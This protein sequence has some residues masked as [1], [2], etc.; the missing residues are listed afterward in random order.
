MK[1][2]D[3][4]IIGQKAY[5]VKGHRKE[6][7]ELTITGFTVDADGYHLIYDNKDIYVGWQDRIFLSEKKANNFLNDIIKREEVRELRNIKNKEYIAKLEDSLTDYDHLVGS[8]VMLKENHGKWYK[9]KIK[10][11]HIVYR[12][13]KKKPVIGFYTLNGSGMYLLSREG[14]NW[15]FW[16]K[17][18]ELNTKLEKLQEQVKDVKKQIKDEEKILKEIQDEESN[19]I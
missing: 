6:I 11:F 4:R 13:S 16:T 8:D 2:Y 17:L 10:G 12:Y 5:F 18:D 15:K 14:K 3:S 7:T 19:T 9:H 1:K